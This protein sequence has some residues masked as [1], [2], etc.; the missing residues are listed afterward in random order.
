MPRR[1]T[2]VILAIAATVLGGAGLAE[3]DLVRYTFSFEGAA[4]LRGARSSGTR[5]N[6]MVRWVAP[7]G[8]F[9]GWFRVDRTRSIVR[10]GRSLATRG[11]W[12][13]AE[14]TVRMAED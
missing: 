1:N 10:R 2:F 9:D 5:S 4:G 14:E 8:S 13:R 11:A 12:F 6:A 7:K 3:A